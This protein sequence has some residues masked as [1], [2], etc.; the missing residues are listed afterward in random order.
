MAC[1]VNVNIVDED[2]RKAVQSYDPQAPVTRKGVLRSL[3]TGQPI[4]IREDDVVNWIFFLEKKN[5]S[6]N[7]SLKLSISAWPLKTC[8]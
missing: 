1:S 7:L 2:Q 6:W 5:C 8:Y 4:E 3:T